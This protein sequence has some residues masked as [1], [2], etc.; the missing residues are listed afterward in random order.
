MSKYMP[1]NLAEAAQEVLDDPDLMSLRDNIAITDARMADVWRSIGEGGLIGMLAD[2]TAAV[3]RFERARNEQEQGQALNA[4][5]RAARGARG[6]QEALRDISTLTE[7]RRRLVETETRRLV[8]GR[9]TLTIEAAYGLISMLVD[10][11]LRHVTDK[12]QRQGILREVQP[13]L[14]PVRET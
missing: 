13:L 9:D 8:A 3:Q 11:V 2:I 4:L 12:Q 5:L 14:S 6:A 1:R 7:E 10:V